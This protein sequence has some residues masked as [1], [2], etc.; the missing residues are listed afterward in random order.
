MNIFI[1]EIIKIKITE[2]VESIQS[3]IPTLMKKEDIEKE[4]DY[5]ISCIKYKKT[6]KKNYININKKCN[7][8]KDN[9]INY[10]S[11]NVKNSKIKIPH[12]IIP[13]NLRCCGRVWGPVKKKKEKGIEK[14]IYGSRCKNK[15]IIGS[16]YCFIH[17]N[18]L[19]HGD[20]LIEPDKFIKEHF[21]NE[22]PK[23]DN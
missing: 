13:D 1:Q 11:V 23:K 21:I 16:K 8:N 14:T 22:R 5:I 12:K 9:N 2:L 7:L 15:K 6:Q 4:I 20:F 19:T 3:N 18:K 10:N 17:N